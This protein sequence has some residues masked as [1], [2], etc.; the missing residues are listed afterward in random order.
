MK[1]LISKNPLVTKIISGKVDS[2]VYDMLFAKQLPF[3]DEEYLESL[4]FLLKKEELKTAALKILKTVPE[5]TKIQYAEKK[6]A[7]HRVVYYILVEALSTENLDQIAKIIQNQSLPIDFLIKIAELGKTAMLEMLIE[8]QIKLIAY[9]NILDVMEKNSQIN[10][11]TKGKIQEIRDF[12]LKEEKA[13][14]ISE[15]DIIDNI[16]DMVQKDEEEHEDESDEITIEEAQEKIFTTLERINELTVPERIK[17][18]L[19]GTRTER[20]ILIKDTNKLVAL[21]VLESPK[22]SEDEI[23]L[24]LRDR[25]ISQEIIAK[26]A[27]NRELSKNYTMI[28]EM[29]QNPKTPLKKAL[30]MVKKLHLKDLKHLTFDKNIHY[31]VRNVAANLYKEKT[32]HR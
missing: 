17:L 12:Y 6:Q 20:M 18:A 1:E 3:T 13:A 32:T 14:L 9:P 30:G 22:L 24:T 26:I 19:T 21:A 2:E 27:N 7:N 10:N 5:Q 11:F 31:V 16:Q 28:L 29:V 23:L 15:D 25:S 4:V 8:N